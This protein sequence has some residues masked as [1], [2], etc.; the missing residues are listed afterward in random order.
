ME[1]GRR[2]H[3]HRNRRENLRGGED[4][5]RKHISRRSPAAGG[6]RGVKVNAADA[7][8]MARLVGARSRYIFFGAF[9]RV[10]D[11][12]TVRWKIVPRYKR[13]AFLLSAAFVFIW[14]SAAVAVW[15]G[16]KFIK[17]YD[18]VSF[19]K[20]ALLPFYISEHRRDMGEY[21]IKRG[22][23][24]IKEKDPSKALQ[25]LYKGVI[26]SPDNLEARVTLAQIYLL[27]LK[28]PTFASTILDDR[29][30]LALEKKN[31]A[32]IKM[33]LSVFMIS[34][35]YAQKFVD[36]SKKLL[37]SKF[38]KESDITAIASPVI[39][40]MHAAKNDDELS[41]I[42]EKFLTEFESPKLNKFFAANL[43]VAYVSVGGFISAWNVVKKHGI[44]GTQIGEEISCRIMWQ[45]N[46][47]LKALELAQKLAKRR[48]NSENAYAMLAE[49]Y[50]ELGD[51]EMLRMAEDTKA[52]MSSDLYSSKL[53]QIER[54]TDEIER[55][56]NIDEYLKT[57]SGSAMAMAKLASYA[58][59]IRDP[60]LMDKCVKVD[61]KNDKLNNF[62][63]LVYVEFLLVTGKIDAAV[64]EL[65]VLSYSF[66]DNSSQK[67]LLEGMQITADAMS[68]KNVE[69]AIRN[70]ALANKS[71][72]AS[73]INLANFLM[74]C[75]LHKETELLCELSK[76]NFPE[77]Y[78][79]KNILAKI[80]SERGDLPSLARLAARTRIP[81]PELLSLEA[82]V[83][84]DAS[85]FLSAEERSIIF[86]KIAH[87]KEVKS[88]SRSIL[89]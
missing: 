9:E 76:E 24:A 1:D 26:Q 60:I 86:E 73:I 57:F 39:K 80:Y 30:D 81:M 37:D 3:G 32:Y 35:D 55:N 28:D 51:E 49:F 25:Y 14:I 47:E 7:H 8:R 43:A 40:S 83:R 34:P 33:A 54:S 16:Y 53:L 52:L 27:G 6:A 68:G 46:N 67:E 66:K 58:V 61:L 31:V 4:F 70:F 22:Y 50:K 88:K 64:E 15:C 13:I 20:V 45:Q 42:L 41:V 74:R 17:R 2:H 29:L 79:I 75:N 85:T 59:K 82:F 65:M 63:R 12:K 18:E 23:E 56:R 72:P 44:A 48:K 77:D 62:I 21:N 71:R 69:G 38:L 19:V 5:G 89:K 78:R 10:F 84:S 36:V 87:A 11:N